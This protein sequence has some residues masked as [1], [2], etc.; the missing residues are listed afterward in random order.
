MNFWKR[1]WQDEAGML[2]SA[3]AVTV[4]TVG[5]LGATVGLSMARTA[6]NDELEEFSLAIRH[7]DQSY[8]VAGQSSARAWTAP[9]MYVQ[10]DIEDSIADMGARVQEQQEVDARQLRESIERFKRE[11][12]DKPESKVDD[13]KPKEKHRKTPKKRLKKQS[14]QEETQ[15]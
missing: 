15:I 6:V 7:L 13:S 11:L 12:K 10:P 9:S 14:S 4:G 3:E 8:A 1:F 5:I 2:V